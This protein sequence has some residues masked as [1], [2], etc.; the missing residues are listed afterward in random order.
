MAVVEGDAGVIVI[1]PAL[2][3]EVSAPVRPP[4]SVRTSARVPGRVT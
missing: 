4:S 2:S 1:D 3:A